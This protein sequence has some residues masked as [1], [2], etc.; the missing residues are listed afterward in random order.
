MAD[1]AAQL[2]QALAETATALE[3][4][5]AVGAAAAS[6]RAA[7]ASQALQSSG[8]GLDPGRLARARELQARCE[9]ASSKQLLRLDAEAK[10]SARSQ[11]AATAYGEQ[12]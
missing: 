12:R 2:E 10:L 6:S 1:P 3:A 5:D 9:A 7:E 8:A 4:G 11:R